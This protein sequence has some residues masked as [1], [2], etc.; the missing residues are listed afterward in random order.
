MTTYLIPPEP[1]LLDAPER[2]FLDE[3]EPTAVMAREG[4]GQPEPVASEAPWTL[5]RLKVE[6][7][8]LVAE[9]R[10][11]ARAEYMAAHP[12]PAPGT[13]Q[14][15]AG[16]RELACTKERTRILGIV[17]HPEAKGREALARKLAAMESM[18]VEGAAEIMGGV[19]VASTGPAAEFLA[20]L[21][22]ARAC[23]VPS[24]EAEEEEAYVK[25]MRAIDA[26]GAGRE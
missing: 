23:P 2:V 14:L 15:I 8:A 26:E 11:T 10:E 20:V 19:P 25:R 4:A 18:S 21:A 5:E 6:E 16:A 1:V 24:S 22:K 12:Q 17:A 7:P 3:L 9:I 13:M